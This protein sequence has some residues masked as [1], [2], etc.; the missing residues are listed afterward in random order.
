MVGALAP[1]VYTRL[2]LPSNNKQGF[3]EEKKKPIPI[4]LKKKRATREN[5]MD[6]FVGSCEGSGQIWWPTGAEIV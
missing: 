1:H 6:R 4:V 2:P 5:A 3:L